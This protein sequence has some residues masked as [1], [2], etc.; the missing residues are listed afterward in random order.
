LLAPAFTLQLAGDPAAAL[1]HW[2]SWLQPSGALYLTVFTPLA[3]L[4]GDLPEGEWH[5]D[6]EALLPDGCRAVLETR[7]TLDEEKQLLHREHRYTVESDPPRR[8]MSRQTIRWFDDGE[9]EELLDQAGFRIT[10]AFLDFD[11]SLDAAST[12]I[13]QTDGILTC[14][15]VRQ[16]GRGPHYPL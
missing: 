8:H 6:H 5:A 13:D 10:S 11:P 7:H 4:S 16:S 15:A 1:R 3:E 9:L 2:T 14:H 12:D